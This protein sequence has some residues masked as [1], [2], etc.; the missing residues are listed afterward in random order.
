MRASWTKLARLLVVTM[1]LVMQWPLVGCGGDDNN[2][3]PSPTSDAGGDVSSSADVVHAD[4]SLPDVHADSSLPDVVQADNVVPTDASKTIT[5]IAVT[6]ATAMIAKGATQQ[7]NATATYND[8][9]T[10]DV[11]STATWSS[12]D[13][14]IATVNNA[15]LATGVAVGQANITATLGGRTGTAVLTVSNA[16]LVGITIAPAAQQSIPKGT[17]TSFVATGQFSDGS[18][19]N[20]SNNPTTMWAATPGGIVSLTAGT[21]AEVVTG[22]AIGMTS[23][24]ASA[25]GCGGTCTSNATTVNVTAATLASIAVTPVTPPTLHINAQQPFLATGTYTDGT[26]QDLT[27][28]ASWSSTNTAY[29]TIVTGGANAGV[30]TG[31]A[32]GTTQITASAPGCGGT[33]TSPAVALTVSSSPLVTITVTPN[34]FSITINTSK[35]FTAMATYQDGSTGDITA[36]AS[37]DATDSSGNPLPSNNISVVAGLA[38]GNAST[39]GLPGN[40]ALVRAHQSGI[41]GSATVKVV[42]TTITS[43]AVSCIGPNLYAY[44]NLACLP[45][46]VGLTVVCQ[47]QATY[48]DGNTDDVTSTAAWAAATPS[49]AMP[50]GLT[51][52]LLPVGM[53]GQVTTGE[54][55]TVV[56]DGTTDVTATLQQVTGHLNAGGGACSPTTCI[57]GASA[58]TLDPT[59]SFCGGGSAIDV[60]DYLTNCPGQTPPPQ[61]AKGQSATFFALAAFSGSCVGGVEYFLANNL[62]SWTSGNTMVASVSNAAGSQGVVSALSPGVS[63]ISANL[64]GLTGF[65]S[66]TVGPACLEA[67]T[68]DQLNPTYPQD[69]LVPLTVK[70]L[71][72]DNT[73]VQLTPGTTVNGNNDSWYGATIDPS[74]WILD[75]SQPITSNPVAFTVA[76]GCTGSVSAVTTITL[77][78]TPPTALA[79]TPQTSTIGLGGTVDYTATAT[80]AL[81][82][83]N[84]AQQAQCPTAPNCWSTTPV[85][86]PPFTFTPDPLPNL[87]ETLTHVG[88][89]G[90][91]FTVNFTYRNQTAT[92][93]LT[94]Q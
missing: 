14:A 12:S 64:G 63:A 78:A 47:A 90:G 75:T 19:V 18:T 34:P 85:N 61:L 40:V 94:V 16:Q 56:A 8:G 88:T 50:V 80:F 30:A 5:S 25:P 20:I 70:G 28:T 67:L 13:S 31:V 82:N 11:T 92:A 32:A 17:T 24:T 81:G 71:Y 52:I 41:T 69:V 53:I 29:A 76:N 43:I 86:S 38:T 79:I 72:S 55:F 83:F 23:I 9:S 42:G 37:W 48:N 3:P 89:N 1:M 22:N 15:G 84:V 4:T 91:N 7:F 27:A 58:E 77:D 68:I 6:P 59:G 46:S 66:L 51:T 87:N 60:L 93:N 26:S 65:Y 54:G 73:T 74:S 10:S 49:V 21:G 44:N 39:F 57:Q 2:N 36:S 35:Q 33:C 62:V 45:T